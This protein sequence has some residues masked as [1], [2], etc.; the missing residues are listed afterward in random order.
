MLIATTVQQIVKRYCQFDN[1][2]TELPKLLL[3]V[4]PVPFLGPEQMVVVGFT[5]HVSTP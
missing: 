1:V 4:G 2:A 3:E 5:G